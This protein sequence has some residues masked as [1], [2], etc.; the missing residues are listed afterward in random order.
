MDNSETLATLGTHDKRQRQTILKHNTNRKLKRLSTR[1]EPKT[2]GEPKCS[3]RVSSCT[4]SFTPGSVIDVCS[5]YV[6]M[7]ITER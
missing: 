2:G 7:Q 5:Y 4:I 1:T 3:R 6:I